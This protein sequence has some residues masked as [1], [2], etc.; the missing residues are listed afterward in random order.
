MMRFQSRPCAISHSSLSEPPPRSETVPGGRL[1]KGSGFFL[2]GGTGSKLACLARKLSLSHW[3]LTKSLI[4]PRNESDG[5]K[6]GQTAFI[7]LTFV[8]VI[9]N[10][11]LSD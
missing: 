3:R 4:L 2:C 8:M 9:V 5:R 10:Y 6:D 1:I 7:L 11:L